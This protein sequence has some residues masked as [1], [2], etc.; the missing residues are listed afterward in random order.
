MN[1]SNLGDI[2]SLHDGHTARKTYNVKNGHQAQ[3][4]AAIIRPNIKVARRSRALANLRLWR[5]LSEAKYS[6]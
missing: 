6:V 1:A 5:S 3:M 2:C 4:K